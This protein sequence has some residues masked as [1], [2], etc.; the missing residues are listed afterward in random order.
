M[1]K[2]FAEDDINEQLT[3]IQHKQREDMILKYR[4]IRDKQ[5]ES[6]KEKIDDIKQVETLTDIIRG[7]KEEYFSD[8]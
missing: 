1:I 4:I 5:Y 8:L 2:R 6:E 7:I 3:P